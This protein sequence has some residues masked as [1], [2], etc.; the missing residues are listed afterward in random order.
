MYVSVKSATYLFICTLVIHPSRDLFYYFQY[1]NN[2][3]AV[4]IRQHSNQ[5]TSGRKQLRFHGKELPSI[6]GMMV[7]CVTE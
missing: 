2:I 6:R 1:S 3:R 7:A 4:N 5:P